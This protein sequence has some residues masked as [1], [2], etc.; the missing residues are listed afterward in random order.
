MAPDGADNDSRRR[1]ATD[2]SN[3][4]GNQESD[5]SDEIPFD[6]PEEIRSR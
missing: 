6:E 5:L 1:E 3:L 4:G 2:S